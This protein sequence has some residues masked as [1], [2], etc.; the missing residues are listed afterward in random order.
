MEL[1][2]IYRGPLPPKTRGVS[3][4]KAQLRSAFHP[5]IKSQVEPRLS[6]E[7]RD[8]VT[9]VVQG[10]IFITPVH[11]EFRTAV[12]LHILLL[13]SASS[14]RAGD[15]DNRL[16]TLIDGLTRP[17]NTQQM[18]DFVPG[19]PDG[20]FCLLDD[21]HLVKRLSVDARTSYEPTD[22]ASGALVVV[23]A[24]IVLNDSADMTS[25][26]GTIFLVL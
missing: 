5:Q 4:I 20:T 17:A 8:T 2:L 24:K 7:G 21:D 22:D 1:T 25:P 19:D 11:P 23:T 18:K 16:K 26:T 10:H 6:R 13:T 14:H 15:L 9:S 12:D 3:P